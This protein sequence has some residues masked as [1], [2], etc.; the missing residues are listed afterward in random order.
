MPSTSITASATTPTPGWRIAK[1]GCA[2]MG[3]P[4]DAR[5]H[6]EVKRRPGIEAAARKLR[7][8]ALGEMAAST[9]CA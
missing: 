8:A 1:P 3:V 4:F 6:V 9:A 7:Y 5:R 2:A